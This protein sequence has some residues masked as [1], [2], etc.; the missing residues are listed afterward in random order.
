MRTTSA[1]VKFL[2]LEPLLAPMPN[3]NLKKIDWVIVG[4]ESGPNSRPVQ[5]EWV[6]DIKQQC[7]KAKVAF[8]FK[9]WGGVRKSQAGRKLDGKIYNE[10][11][12]IMATI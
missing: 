11:P 4:G 5:K 6:V 1:Q 2:S 8:F 12:K 9:Q 3:L 10:M 7:K